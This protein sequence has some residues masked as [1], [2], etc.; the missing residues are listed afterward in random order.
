MQESVPDILHEMP[1]TD[2][3]YSK[4]PY[5]RS[6]APRIVRYNFSAALLRRWTH[7]SLQSIA[8]PEGLLG[9]MDSCPPGW[10]LE[11]QLSLRFCRKAGSS[12]DWC[13]RGWK[14]ISE[15]PWCQIQDAVDA[16]PPMHVPVNSSAIAPCP[17]PQLS[18]LPERWNAYT[19]WLYDIGDNSSH[20]LP[21]VG[22]VKVV[23][24]RVFSDRALR[25]IVLNPLRCSDMRA[26][27]SQAFS[28]KVNVHVPEHFAWGLGKFGLGGRH[29]PAKSKTWVEITHCAGSKFERNAQP[30]FYIAPGSG[31][32]VNVGQTM[33][34]ATHDEGARH[35][36]GKSCKTFECDEELLNMTAVAAR[37]FDSL[38]FTHHCDGTCGLCQHELVM[39]RAGRRRSVA[40]P[41][42]EALE[43][44]RGVGATLPCTCTAASV[45]SYG[46]GTCTACAEMLLPARALFPWEAPPTIPGSGPL[47]SRAFVGQGGLRH[48][49]IRSVL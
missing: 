12:G 15:P 32:F 40:S 41:C 5:L 2:G 18:P 30:W 25:A 14:R 27:G 10:P 35:F 39:L 29:A 45:S 3:F 37:L 20:L 8:K 36:L 6:P 24:V 38:Q 11:Q 34:F 47:H 49:S 48:E 17:M 33:A 13:S 26:C 21:T 42:H 19:R 28:A 9:Q 7:Q 22:E 23:H 16:D 46:R 1:L 31:M 4:F 44:R 43:Y